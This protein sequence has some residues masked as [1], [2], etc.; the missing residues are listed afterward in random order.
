MDTGWKSKHIG[1]GV[2][3]GDRVI[4]K[5][6]HELRSFTGTSAYLVDKNGCYVSQPGK[7]YKQWPLSKLKRLH[8]NGNWLMA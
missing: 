1:I 2:T 7:T 5:E 8:P 6:G 3:C 4:L